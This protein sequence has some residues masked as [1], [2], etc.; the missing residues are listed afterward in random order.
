MKIIWIILKKYNA[1]QLE[2]VGAYW[3]EE[4]AKKAIDLLPEGFSLFILSLHTV[5]LHGYMIDKK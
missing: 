4:E 5:E 3:N 1:G 2:F